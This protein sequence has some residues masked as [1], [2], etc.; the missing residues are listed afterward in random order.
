M[1]WGHGAHRKV[2]AS[3]AA[4]ALLASLMTVF[5]PPAFGSHGGSHGSPPSVE[6]ASTDPAWNNEYWKVQIDNGALST[7]ETN[8]AGAISLDAEG[9]GTNNND[10]PVYRT[11]LNFGGSVGADQVL[12]GTWETGEIRTLDLTLIGLTHVTF[13]FTDEGSEEDEAPVGPE[14]TT[15]LVSSTTTTAAGP[16]TTTAAGPTTTTSRDSWTTTT[17]GESTTTPA[18]DET[19]SDAA[20]SADVTDSAVAGDESQ[21]IESGEEV[22]G[23]KIDGSEWLGSEGSDDD[24]DTSDAGLIFGG[25]GEPPALGQVPISSNAIPDAQ[26]SHQWPTPLDLAILGALIA[27]IPVLVLIDRRKL[28]LRRLVGKAHPANR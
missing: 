23:S 28:D 16:T 3:I 9:A 20:N 6:C 22:E 27:A 17:P 12:S 15:T 11:V 5:S 21:P 26:I 4:S 18:Y 2:L 1:T 14:P 25:S 8:V 10:D 7:V 24:R 19:T 13:C